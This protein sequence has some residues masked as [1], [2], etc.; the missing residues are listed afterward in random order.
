MTRR[1]RIIRRQS[2]Y[3]IKF[4]GR[5]S[6]INPARYL[7]ESE[8]MRVP[9]R[10]STFPWLSEILLPPR[11]I[12]QDISF[13]NVPFFDRPSVLVSS[14]NRRRE[15]GIAKDYSQPQTKAIR[16]G[17]EKEKGLG[18]RKAL[19]LRQN[20]ERRS[21]LLRPVQGR[22][23]NGFCAGLNVSKLF[24]ELVRDSRIARN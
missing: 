15:L 7:A 3:R 23:W 2:Y 19:G 14:P 18:R 22:G 10:T 11:P 20:V 1:F 21:Q 4:I 12:I 24:N 17:K 16:A 9:R 8:T 13:F 5:V 6:A